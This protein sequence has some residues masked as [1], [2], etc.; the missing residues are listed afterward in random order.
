MPHK[1]F[2]LFHTRVS[3]VANPVVRTS[4]A[5]TDNSVMAS[6]NLLCHLRL[7]EEHGAWADLADLKV[8]RLTRQGLQHWLVATS[9]PILTSVQ[10][11]S[12]IWRVRG[13][14]GELRGAQVLREAG[15]VDVHSPTVPRPLVDVVQ[16]ALIAILGGQDEEHNVLGSCVLV[17]PILIVQVLGNPLLAKAPNFLLSFFPGWKCL[18]EW[19]AEGCVQVQLVQGKRSPGSIVETCQLRRSK[20]T[21]G[22]VKP[23][24]S[25]VKD[26]AS[27]PTSLSFLQALKE[28]HHRSGTMIG[29][30]SSHLQMVSR[31]RN[32][33]VGKDLVWFIVLEDV[34]CLGWNSVLLHHEV[35]RY[36]RAIEFVIDFCPIG[37]SPEKHG[38]SVD[39]FHVVGMAVGE[40]ELVSGS[41]I[42]LAL[43]AVKPITA[44]PRKGCELSHETAHGDQVGKEA[45]EIRAEPHQRSHSLASIFA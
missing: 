44:D 38:K 39:A 6:S 30:D 8:T 17:H 42:S 28:K 21:R 16:D 20:V 15:L 34:N 27:H 9:L 12:L 29:R 33:I 45:L 2:Q 37:L 31:S 26:P 35:L 40:K 18:V 22:V 5:N 13:A 41:N 36:F 3:A 25:C 10:P 7:S 43:D 1:S 32:S 19:A 23:E 11:L 4:L 24:V 14:G